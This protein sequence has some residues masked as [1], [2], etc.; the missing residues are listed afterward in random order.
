MS[1]FNPKGLEIF[2][3]PPPFEHPS[4]FDENGVNTYYRNK[5]FTG[6]N[7]VFKTEAEFFT[8]DVDNAVLWDD[9]AFELVFTD[10]KANRYN[11]NYLLL[12]DGR[13]CDVP[14]FFTYNFGDRFRGSKVANI[15]Q[16]NEFIELLR[17]NN[18]SQIADK[19]EADA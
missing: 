9:P 1:T 7:W 4:H 18:H 8:A 13:Y 12:E 11:R 15:Y 17:D 3:K 16:Y 19:L 2:L 10:N 14:A 6:C 5:G